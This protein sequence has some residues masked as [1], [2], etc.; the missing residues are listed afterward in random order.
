M[1]KLCLLIDNFIEKKI[2]YLEFIDKIN[3]LENEE[4][5]EVVNITNSSNLDERMI[6]ILTIYLFKYQYIDLNNVSKNPY[7]SFI[8]EVFDYTTLLD[9][10]YLTINNK[11]L[12]AKIITKNDLA[13]FI[14]NPTSKERI[15]ELPEELQ[16]KTMFCFNCNDDLDLEDSIELPDYSFYT[17]KNE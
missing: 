1:S 5:K 2:K 8:K 7:L 15:V 17:L 6:A 12:I 3:A 16:Y 11:V 4:F 13:Y 14:L 9:V 10:T